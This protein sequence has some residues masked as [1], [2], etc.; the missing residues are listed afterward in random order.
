M[1]RHLLKY[2]PLTRRHLSLG[3]ENEDVR[4]GILGTPALYLAAALDLRSCVTLNP[5]GLDQRSVMDSIL[6]TSEA[7]TGVSSVLFL[8]G[9][10]CP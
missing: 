3:A 7:S 4:T 1:Y 10:P 6:D 5:A 9:D 8:L 2:P